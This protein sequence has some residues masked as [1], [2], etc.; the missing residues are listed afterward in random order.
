MQTFKQLYESMVKSVLNN[1]S[2]PEKDLETSYDPHHLDCLLNPKKHPVVIR[3]GTCNCSKEEREEC[4][5]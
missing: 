1:D 3:T 4:L 5:K 2:D